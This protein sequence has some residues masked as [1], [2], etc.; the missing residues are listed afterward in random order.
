MWTWGQ[1]SDGNLGHNVGGP[2]LPGL[3]SPTQ[4]PGTNWGIESYQFAQGRDFGWH[5]RT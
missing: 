2:S 5:L 3:S 4:L 1:N